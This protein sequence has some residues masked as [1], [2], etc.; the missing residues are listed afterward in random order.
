MKELMLAYAGVTLR[1]S[2]VFNVLGKRTFSRS[3]RF[4]IEGFFFREETDQLGSLTVY[5]AMLLVLWLKKNRG[6]VN[7]TDEDMF[8]RSPVNCTTIKKT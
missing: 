8:F 3:C 7:H 5:C 1:Q 4:D 2:R 6:P